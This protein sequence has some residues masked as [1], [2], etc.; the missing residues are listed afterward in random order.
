MVKM[1][2]LKFLSRH[3]IETPKDWEQTIFNFIIDDS[4]TK[5]NKHQNSD[6]KSLEVRLTNREV[7]S[8]INPPDNYQ[9]EQAF[10]EI[11]K[12]YIIAKIEAREVIKDEEKL[13]S[14]ALRYLYLDSNSLENFHNEIIKI[15]IQIQIQ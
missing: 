5:L 12:N 3:I 14:N 15:Q 1:K 2:Y 9:L 7:A 11:A 6:K 13:Y 4:L 8:I 10:F